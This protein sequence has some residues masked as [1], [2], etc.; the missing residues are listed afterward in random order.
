MQ[1][2][3]CKQADNWVKLNI[4]GSS[5][6][7]SSLVN[8]GDIVEVKYH[9]GIWVSGFSRAVDIPT[10]VTAEPWDIKDEL[11][12]FNQLQLQ[13]DKGCSETVE[14]V[15]TNIDH[16]DP[17]I[18]VVHKIVKCGKALWKWSLSCFGNVR[19]GLELKRKITSA[20]REGGT[21]VR[22]KFSGVGVKKWS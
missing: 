10:S 18:L 4:N 16:S 9:R 17:G 21:G 15:W 19:M 13:L 6:R 22:G 8:A 14:T 2:E 1:V 3:R 20:S 11:N 5:L 12:L 7:N